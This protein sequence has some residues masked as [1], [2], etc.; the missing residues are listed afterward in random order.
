MAHILFCDDDSNS[1]QILGKAAELLGHHPILVNNGSAVVDQAADRHPDLILID[2]YMP[3]MDGLQV[4]DSLHQNPATS[5]IPVLILSAGSTGDL[6]SRARL[7]GAQ[8][9]LVKPI[10]LGVLLDTIKKYT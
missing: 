9:Y 6:S 1:L 4:L 8:G 7:S 10:S 3:D 2:L 5:S